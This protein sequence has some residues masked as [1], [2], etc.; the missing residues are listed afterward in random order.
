MTERDGG[1]QEHPSA[2]GKGWW[3][4]LEQHCGCQELGSSL[5]RDQTS[6]QPLGALLGLEGRGRQ[7]QECQNLGQ[8]GCYWC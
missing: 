5:G 4:D 7:G 2:Y 8:Q 3:R 1:R 6:A